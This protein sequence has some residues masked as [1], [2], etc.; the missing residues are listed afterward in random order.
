VSGRCAGATHRT[1]AHDA[2]DT[3]ASIRTV[4]TSAGPAVIDAGILVCQARDRT[5]CEARD[6]PTPADAPP[7]PPTVPLGI[8]RADAYAEFRRLF[9]LKEFDAA[10]KQGQRVVELAE[11]DPSATGDELQSR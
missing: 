8:A 7:P 11:S 10:A 6:R 2:V 3:S 1:A 4:D 5:D 9:D